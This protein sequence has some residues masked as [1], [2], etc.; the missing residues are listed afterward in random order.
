MNKLHDQVPP[1]PTLNQYLRELVQMAQSYPPKSPKRRQILGKLLCEIQNSGLL[2][3]PACPAQ[4]HGCYKEIYATALQNIF[5]YICQHIE[6]YNPNVGEVLNWVNFLLS[7]RFPDA[8]AE[9]VQSAKYMDFKS[10]KIVSIE[11]LSRGGIEMIN[12][13]ELLT[14]SLTEQ[15]REVLEE[16]PEGEFEGRFMCSNPLANFKVIALKRLAGISWEELSAEYHSKVAALSNF[17]QRSL[18]HFVPKI[19]KYLSE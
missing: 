13:Q 9:V 12:P 18:T 6:L 5:L 1:S 7:R 4:Y 3:H 2:C 19:K 15:I 11:D 14:P 8:I 16:D 17:Y 10:V